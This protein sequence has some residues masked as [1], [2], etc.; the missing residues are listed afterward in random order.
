MVLL[1][2]PSDSR[3]RRRLRGR[4]Q[5]RRDH[6]RREPPAGAARAGGGGRAGRRRARARPADEVE[7]LRRPGAV[8]AAR[9]TTRT[10]RWRSVFTSGTTGQPKGA[11]FRDRQLAAVTRIDVGR[12]LGRSRRAADPDAGGHPVRPRRLHDQAAVVP[13]AR[14]DHA[15]AR[16]VAGRR[17]PARASPSTASRRSAAWPRRSRCCCARTSTPYDLDVRADARH[18]RR[19]VAAGAGARGRGPLRR[20]RTRSATRRPSAAAAAPAP[21]STPTT[22][23]RCFTVGRPRGGIE[24]GICDDEAGPAPRRRGR[25]GVAALAHVDGG[26]LARPRGAPPTRS[27][28]RLAAHRRPRPHRRRAAACASPGG[29]KEMFIRGGYNVYPAEVEARAGRPPVGRRGR[30]SSP[31]PT[32]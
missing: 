30:S 8:A 12:R 5:G 29:C 9:S 1:R 25:R 2:L 28:R 11:L 7:A 31:G 20:R 17:R 10:G 26:L 22:T 6:R 4:R 24:V 13:A 21:R 16:P 18:G 3:L 14:H 27:S 19:G 32:T 23:R 15:R